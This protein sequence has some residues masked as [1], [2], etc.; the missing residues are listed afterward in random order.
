MSRIR[1]RL[2]GRLAG[3]GR[4]LWP[5][6]T[7][8]AIAIAAMSIVA[9]QTGGGDR[10]RGHDRDGQRNHDATECAELA[11][12][13]GAADCEALK[14]ALDDDQTLAQ[15]AESNG[16]EPQTV[17][18]AMVAEMTAE[19]DAKVE[20]SAITEERAAMLRT[21]LTVMVS[22]GVNEGFGRDHGR[23]GERGRDLF[24]AAE[25]AELATL[26]GADDCAAFKSALRDGQT[27][28]EIAESNGI[29][30]QTVIDA[31]VA[32]MSAELDAKVASGDLTE[33]R[34]AMIRTQITDMVV[35]FVNEGFD[36]EREHRGHGKRGHDMFD[37]AEC[38]ELATLVG[39]DD[40]A[41]LK[42]AMRG[43]QTLAQIAESNDIEPQTVID[44]MVAE[45]SAEL[46]AKVDSGAI[47]EE[48]AAMIREQLTAMIT[49]FVNEGFD[50][51]RGHRGKT[52][53]AGAAPRS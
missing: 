51:E 7:A 20:S 23:R 18:D 17:I 2:T 42:T 5:A 32:E 49:G 47:T 24:D 13:V 25:C 8:V 12:L 43:G 21:Q 11:A 50:G 34:A 6:V 33:E 36:G 41:A 3:K 44:A 38:A 29:E 31:L 4:W 37:A 53:R 52:K 46:D 14:T 28:A 15:I 45:M 1:N 22:E 9:A 35:G 30:P 40:C 26:V 16:I 10:S 48:R 39:A 27:P 19:L